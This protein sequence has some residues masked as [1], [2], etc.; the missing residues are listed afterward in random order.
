[1]DV[2]VYYISAVKIGKQYKIYLE[3]QNSLNEKDMI[4]S[5]TNYLEK[6]ILKNPFQFFHFYDFFN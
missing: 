2:P 5:Y 4:T 6:I 3:K 1:M